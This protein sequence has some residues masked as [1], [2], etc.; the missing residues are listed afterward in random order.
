[1]WRRLG[2]EVTVIEFLDAIIPGTLKIQKLR[3]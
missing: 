2:T 1:V 3:M